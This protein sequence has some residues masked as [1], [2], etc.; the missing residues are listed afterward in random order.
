MITR[1]EVHYMEFRDCKLFQ[2]LKIGSMELK[3]RVGVAPMTLSCEDKTGLVSEGQLN[4]YKTRAAGGAGFIEMD[5]VT[6]DITVPYRGPTTSLDDDRFIAPMRKVVEQIHSYGCKLIP[7]IIHAGPESFM[8]FMGKNPP[9][10]SAYMNDSG[11]MTRAIDISEIPDIVKKYGAACR[12]A[13]EA[14]FDGVQIHCGHAYMLPGAFLS[15]LR[16][17]RGDEYGGSLD[18]RARLILEILAEVRRNVSPDFP[19]I[20]RISGDERYPGGNTLEDMLYLAP[21]LV[22]AGASA[23][24]VSGGANYEAPWH[25][26]PCH[27]QPAGINV[28]E[29]AAIKKVVDVPVL[30]VGK[31]NDIRY[32]ADLIERGVVDAVVMGRPFFAEPDLVNKAQEGRFEDIAPCASCGGCVS[33]DPDEGFHGPKCHINPR[34]LHELEFPMVPTEGPKKKVLVIGGGIGGMEAAYTAAVRGHS[35]TLWERSGQLGGHLLLACVPPAKQDLA[36]WIVY[37]STQ[38]KKHGVLVE[39]HKDATADAVRAMAPD[40]VILASGADAAVP[41]IPGVEEHPVSTAYEFLEGKFAIPGGRVC[42]L[43][44]GFVACETAET[45]FQRAIGDVDITLVDALPVVMK[46]YTRYNRAPLLRRLRENHAHILTGTKV[47]AYHGNGVTVELPDG[48]EKELSGFTHVIFAL[49]A[50]SRDGLA[51]ELEAFVP[52]VHVIGEAK[53]APRMAVKAVQEGFEV[54]YSL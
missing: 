53:K 6:I 4:F 22:A 9:A 19:I 27:G 41:P 49:G 51:S 33:Y 38:I 21:K 17:H 48:T 50:T 37:L 45:I 18:N 29:A 15:P 5:A 16:N 20:L 3:N 23:F 31:I 12:R 34:L 13:E 46:N 36:K 7:Q 25:I 39:L 24:E 47:I 42:I 11:N 54:A 40:V 26:I 10:P 14:G 8:G 44:A 2:P 43:G 52:E 28:P 32:G 35:V 1:K 30:V